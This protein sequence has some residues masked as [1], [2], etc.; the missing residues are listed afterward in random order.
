MLSRRLSLALMLYPTGHHVSAWRDPNTQ[1]DAGIDFKHYAKATLTAEQAGFEIA[2]VPDRLAIPPTRP[3]ALG[4]VDEWSHGFEAVTLASAL[5]AITTDIGIVATASTTFNEPYN[6]ARQ[7][8]SLDQ[9]SNGRAGWNIV[10]SSLE[11]E[12]ANF[13]PVANFEHSARYERAEEFLIAVEALWNSWDVSAFSRDKQSGVFFDPAGLRPADHQGKYFRAAGPLNILPSAQGRPLLVQAGSSGPGR[14]LAARYADLVFTA[15]PNMEAGR[16][17]YADIKRR[18]RA[19]GRSD[20]QLQILPG[21]STIIGR[22]KDEAEDKFARLQS[23]IQPEVALALLE[24]YLGDVDLSGHDIDGPLPA[25]PE[26]NTI[27]SRQGLLTDL[28]RRENLSIRQLATRIAGA[29]GHF[30]PVGTPLEISD[31]I[32]DWFVSGAADGFVVMPPTFPEGLDDFVQLIVP[33]LARRG[34]LRDRAEPGATLHQRLGLPKPHPFRA[35]TA[36]AR[37]SA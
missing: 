25:L 15:H 6:L 23:L 26:S 7:F 30:A 28:A 11:T 18:A 10:T 24:T 33:E 3:D 31:A 35:E 9:L 16:A 20:G 32:E 27:K 21:I 19:A 17:F 22:T 29:R 4:R 8:A 5:A 14:D 34:L 1:V 13:N 2:F 36:P 37:A 12:L